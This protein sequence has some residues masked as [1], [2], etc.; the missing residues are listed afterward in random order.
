MEP[1]ALRSEMLANDGH[2]EVSA[3]LTAKLLGQGITIMT[4]RVGAPAHLPKELLPLVPGQTA[5]LEIGPGPF[6][7]MVEEALVV[8]LRLE[9]LDFRLDEF[10][11]GC[12]IGLKFCW[13]F[14]IH[15]TYPPC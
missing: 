8:V 12:Q 5:V 3:I 1:Q 10:I 9:R 6:A 2:A 15:A 4:R 7:P 11:E 13:N 14:E